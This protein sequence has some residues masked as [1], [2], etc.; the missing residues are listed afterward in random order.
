VRTVQDPGDGDC[1]DRD[2]EETVD[3]GGPEG[4]EVLLAKGAS[5]YLRLV[6][7]HESRERLE[8]VLRAQGQA[9]EA[10]IETSEDDLLGMALVVSRESDRLSTLETMSNLISEV[11]ALRPPAK[12]EDHGTVHARLAIIRGRISRINGD[13]PGAEKW[14]AG[15]A[16][17][18]RMVPWQTVAGAELGLSWGMLKWEC[19]EF[20]VAEAYLRHAARTYSD[21]GTADEEAEARVCLGMVVSEREQPDSALK[22]LALGRSGLSRSRPGLALWARYEEAHAAARLGMKARAR[23]LLAEDNP[24]ESELASEARYQWLRGKV[25]VEIDGPAA[26]REL[27]SARVQLLAKR[28]Y[29]YGALCSFDLVEL[30]L[31]QGRRADANAVVADLLQRFQETPNITGLAE[32]AEKLFARGSRTHLTPEQLK[33]EGVAELR[34]LLRAGHHSVL[35]PSSL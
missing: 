12:A 16:R 29:A 25:L 27:E 31:A 7:L 6:A 23:Q 32:W 13:W 22:L 20:D 10:L 28:E 18:L 15:A 5:T 34:R 33:T 3:E 8:E 17:L 2:L 30:L 14:F 24:E 9:R 21:F 11:L 35:L 26:E 19:G 4:S 1:G